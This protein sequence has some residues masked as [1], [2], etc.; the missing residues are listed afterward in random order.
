MSKKKEAKGGGRI[1]TP[2]D[3]MDASGVKVAP[4]SPPPRPSPRKETKDGGSVATLAE[5]AD[6]IAMVPA[7]KKEKKGGGRITTP[8]EDSAEAGRTE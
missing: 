2:V 4:P 1:T 5:A 3:D 8:V 7:G 6:G